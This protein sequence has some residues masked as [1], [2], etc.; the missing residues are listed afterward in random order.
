MDSLI[1]KALQDAQ[2]DVRLTNTTDN[3]WLVWEAEMKE[4]VVYGRQPG[5]CNTV[6]HINTTDLN[7]AIEVLTWEED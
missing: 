5:A 7:E 2:I 4:W 1:I 6:C 3:K